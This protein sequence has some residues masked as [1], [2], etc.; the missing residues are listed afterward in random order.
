M[1]SAVQ[2][3]HGCSHARPPYKLMHVN[4]HCNMYMRVES[5]SHTTK[6]N[7]KRLAYN[8]DHAA[9]CLLNVG[10][11]LACRGGMSEAIRINGIL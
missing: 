9:V 3:G 10:N 4:I 8:A 5:H 2:P 1:V 6:L 7:A 11:G